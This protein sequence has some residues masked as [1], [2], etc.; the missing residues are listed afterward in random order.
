[1]KAV[2]EKDFMALNKAAVNRGI[3][4]A[5]DQFQFR[6]KHDIRRKVRRENGKHVNVQAGVN[7]AVQTRTKFGKLFGVKFLLNLRIQRFAFLSTWLF[8]YMS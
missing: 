2:A 6:A 4:N 8:S 5:K 3:V 7:V 1:M